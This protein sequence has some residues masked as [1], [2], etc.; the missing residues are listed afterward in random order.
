[1]PCPPSWL[2]RLHEIR[3][4]VANSVRSHY[5]RKDIERLF[6]LQPRASQKL[7]ALLPTEPVGKA[8]LVEREALAHFLDQ[9]HEAGD[10][11]ALFARLRRENA[12][13]TRRKLRALVRRDAEPSTLDSLPPNVALT[14]GDLHIA[15]QS[16][17]DLA[18]ALGS[19]ARLLEGDLDELGR[20]IE[21]VSEPAEPNPAVDE[22]AALYNGLEQLQARR[23]LGR[24]LVS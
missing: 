12:P 3:R 14:P 18:E 8:H 11:I 24:H 5:E 6:E 15:F 16:L 20:R 9:V 1:M 17:Q 2:P 7:L 21:V 13:T 19:V 23:S 4:A 22:L 10:T